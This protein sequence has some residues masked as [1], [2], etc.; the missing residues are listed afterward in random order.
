MSLLPYGSAPPSR[1]TVY[2]PADFVVAP[3]LSGV[4]ADYYTTGTNDHVQ[5][6]AAITAANALTNGGTVELRTGTYVLGA[7]IVPLNN[8]WLR[9]QGMFSTVITTGANANYSLID[10]YSVHNPASPWQNA[11]LSDFT[12]DGTNQNPAIASK[13]INSNALVD[14]KFMR[15]NCH[16]TT[17]TGLGAD[18][19]QSV[20]VTEC[21]VKNCGYTNKHT[22][23]AASWAAN[24]FTF[25]VPSHGYSVG[26]SIVIT[27]M[28]PILYN[29]TYKVTSVTDANNFTIG[30]S[31]NSGGLNFTLDPGTATTFGVTSDSLIGHN[32]IGIATG[33]LTAESMIITNNFCSGNQNNNFLSEADTNTTGT[34]A[35]YIWSNNVSVSAGSIGYLNTGT[36]NVQ[37]NNNYD[38]GSPTAASAN[39]VS[40]SKTITAASWSGGVATFTTSTSHGYAVGNNVSILSMTPSAY[41]GYYVVQS[42][43]STT[44]TVNITSD[45]GT[46]TVFGQSQIVTHPVDGSSFIDNVFAY[47]LNY[48]VKLPS[49]SNGIM[50]KNNVIKG[51]YNYGIQ[52]NSSY[53]QFTGNRIYNCGRQGVL[54]I[55]GGGDQ[56][57][58]SRVDISS[59][60]IYNNGQ[61][62]ANSDGIDL[63]GSS[64]SSAFLQHITIHDNQ[65]F[66]DQPT[67]TQRYGVILRSGGTLTNISVFNN[68]LSTNLTAGILVQNTGDKIFVDN[69]VG[70]N[71]LGKSDL[72]NITGSTTFDSSLASY[73]TGTLT[74][75]I[76]AVMPSNAV[77]GA[78]M[79]W[80]LTQD[81]TGGRTI[82]L[83]ANAVASGTLVTSL[84]ASAN[85]IYN[86][87]YDTGTSKWRQQTVSALSTGTVPAASKIIDVNGNPVLDVT[88]TASAIAGFR[89]T[90]NVSGGT[91]TLAN[92]NTGNSA[93]VIQGSGSGLMVLQPA[94]NSTNALRFRSSGGSNTHLLYD[95][96]NGRFAIGSGTT[97]VDVLSVTGNVNLLA[98][99]N[100]LLIATGSNASVGTGTLTAGTV[101]ISTT[102]VTANSKIFLQDTSNS[103]TN[104]GTLTAPSSGITAGTSFVVTSTLALDTS[105]F[106]WLIIN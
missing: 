34:N 91:V 63:N 19:Y 33:S 11:I 43:T 88:A 1:K 49:Q 84:T 21:E 16:D 85:D 80:L 82:T 74:G 20:T 2:S 79:T 95:S 9:G 98:A 92:S 64:S 47:N 67:Q 76:T 18:D 50:V 65:I 48:G 35:T 26:N 105:T 40:A 53:S 52:S 83:P 87:V 69:N 23:T 86:W 102:A 106:N 7:T 39:Q 81:A 103:I 3:L 32:G 13:G 55:T 5:I 46:A 60:H 99:G 68:D 30:S 100:K 24:V 12:L 90:N 4:K 71:P 45:P 77:E 38:Y 57:P 36:P 56:A 22:I 27:G 25:T 15:I 6:N 97:P 89:I 54:L 96:S 94:S 37:C 66:D 75:N 58:M 41:N 61:R 8:V 28:V 72:G 70:V 44:F 14:C 73:F 51:S 101:T 78:T 62:V 17:A 31:N 59:N 42:V 10:N 93:T 104:V 29:G